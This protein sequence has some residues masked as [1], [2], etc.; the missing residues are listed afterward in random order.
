MNALTQVEW[1]L[2]ELKKGKHLTM[3]SMLM[4]YGIG[5]HTG[6]ITRCRRALLDEG[7]G[8]EIITEWIWTRSRKTGKKIKFASYYIPTRAKKGLFDRFRK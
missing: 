4:D 3:L 1:T 5:N 7:N 6:V 2:S 8:E